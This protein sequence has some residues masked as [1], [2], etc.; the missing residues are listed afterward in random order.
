VRDELEGVVLR[1]NGLNL[2]FGND[3][4][5]YLL[6][7]IKL[8]LRHREFNSNK[9]R[10]ELSGLLSGVEFDSNSLRVAGRILSSDSLRRTTFHTMDSGAVTLLILREA[11]GLSLGTAA[12]HLN[13]LQSYRIISPSVRLL[14]PMDADGGPRV[15]IYQTPDASP[16]QVTSVI[17]L[18]RRLESPKYRQ[19]IRVAEKLLIDHPEILESCET[20]YGDIVEYVKIMKLNYN[21]SDIIQLV[22]KNLHERGVKVWR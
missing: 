22:S 7:A 20:R 11:L 6:K 3:S 2:R 19:A 8:L 12:R 21:T 13:D 9:S 5:Y 4:P 17:E 15:K 18:Q 10:C 1:E 16:D 14:R